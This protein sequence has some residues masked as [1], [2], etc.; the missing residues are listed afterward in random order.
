[1]AI[2]IPIKNRYI[3]SLILGFTAFGIMLLLN[4]LLSQYVNE[5]EEKTLDY[6]FRNRKSVP[7]YPYIST[8][9]IEKRSL[10]MLGPWPWD[11][12]L[13][14]RMVDLLASL[15]V[16]S[17]NFDIF[18]PTP[19]GEAGDRQFI[20]A[21]EN[22]GNVM[23]AST[24]EVVDHPCF[25]PKEYQQFLKSYP[26][27]EEIIEPLKSRLGENT[28]IDFNTMTEEQLEQLEEIAGPNITQDIISH[29]EFIFASEEDE[30]KVKTLLRV[31]DYPFMIE[32]PEK[33][34][35]ANQA[36]LS[37][38]PLLEAAS[39][40]GHVVLQP[41]SDGVLRKVPLVIRAKDRFL[42]HMTLLAV[43]RYLQVTPKRVEVVPGKHIVL[44]EAR[45]PD[46]GE[47]IDLKI[48]VDERAQ[49]RI[50]FP[51]TWESYPFVDVLDV[52]NYSGIKF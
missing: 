48:P 14:A 20:Q 25:T 45:F 15:E 39:G 38:T 23:L 26:H 12:S 10:E 44:R 37:L 7:L 19:S 41:D 28:C 22:A 36:L 2:K 34:W 13:H 49:L 6:R 33:L 27:A 8:I 32:Q 24:F 29:A 31:A 5:W 11:R 3:V 9:G 47:V 42:P 52:E 43:M 46:S 35:Y 4:S 51:P 40:V 21:V 18:F 30:Q 1:M 16:S 50:N 17:M